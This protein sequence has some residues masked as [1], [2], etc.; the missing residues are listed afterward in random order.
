MAK[1][2]RITVVGLCTIFRPALKY[3]KGTCSNLRVWPWRHYSFHLVQEVSVS[4][5]S[6]KPYKKINHWQLTLPCLMR[7]CP[8]CL[9]LAMVISTSSPATWGQPVIEMREEESSCQ[10]GEK[11][12]H[13]EILPTGGKKSDPPCIITL[14]PPT[15]MQFLSRFRDCHFC[16]SSSWVRS[17]FLYSS[18]ALS[19]WPSGKLIRTLEESG[20]NTKLGTLGGSKGGNEELWS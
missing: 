19:L 4:V 20:V 9:L 11:Q 2:L 18:W 12:K 14:S 6:L 5:S 8:L 17:I 1:I 15:K 7:Y 13:S 10:S 3:W 16:C